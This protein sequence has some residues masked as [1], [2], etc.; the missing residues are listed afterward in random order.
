MH[1]KVGR[2]EDPCRAHRGPYAARVGSGLVQRPARPDQPQAKSRVNGQRCE[3]EKCFDERECRDAFVQPHRS[4]KSSFSPDGA[5]IGSSVQDEKRPKR[6]DSTQREKPASERM[7][8]ED[9][10]GNV[11]VGHACYRW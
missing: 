11:V 1:R 3:D 9:G 2:D 8:S 4:E 5:E 6:N 10:G 7:G